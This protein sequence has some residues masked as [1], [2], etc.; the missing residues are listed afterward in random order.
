MPELFLILY[1]INNNVMY[2]MYIPNFW[3]EYTNNA[4]KVILK[5]AL[6]RGHKV[7]GIVRDI[8]KVEKPKFSRRR[9]TV[10]Y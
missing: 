7:T 3:G 9:F 8:S 6:L 5:E 2:R 4:G 10:G 1:I